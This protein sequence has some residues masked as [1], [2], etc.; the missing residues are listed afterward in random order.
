MLLA[1]LLLGLVVAPAWHW[2]V[3]ALVA[4]ALGFF[5]VRQP[6]AM[7][8]KT[9]KR[10][11]TNRAYLWRW[12]T[13]YGSLALLSGGWLVLGQGLWWLPVIGL[14]GGLL[15]IFNLWLV[16]RRQEMSLVGELAGVVGLA[17]GA[18]LTYY[19]TSGQLDS[20]AAILGL[21]NFLYFG[22]TVF[23]IK[24]KVRQQPRQPAPNR[25]SE[26]FVAA[27][28]CLAYQTVALMLLILLVT[29]RQAP[30]LIPLV[31]IPAAIKTL[32]GAWRWQDKKSLS[33]IRLG[34]I[35]ILHTIAFLILVVLSFT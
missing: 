2:R 17:L 20:T 34:V 16:S 24:L 18:P 12:T 5:L 3:L 25:V 31:L 32:Y 10:A 9:R 27:K 15:L 33:L 23:Y 30:M 26:R 22:G 29:L 21:I 14:A 13:I 4:A 1:P 35:E 6:L 8:V 11:S 19:A 28:A 7:W